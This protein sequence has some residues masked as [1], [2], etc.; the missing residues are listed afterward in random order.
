[1]TFVIISFFS[2]FNSAIGKDITNKKI[3]NLK[4]KINRIFLYS[5]YS[6]I[7]KGLNKTNNYVLIIL[8]ILAVISTLIYYVLINIFKLEELIIPFQIEF[9]SFFF[10]MAFGFNTKKKFSK[11]LKEIFRKLIKLYIVIAIL[12]NLI[13]LGSIKFL[14]TENT[15]HEILIINLKMLGIYFGVNVL[16]FFIYKLFPQLISVVLSFFYKYIAKQIAL[17]DKYDPIS[18]FFR[19]LSYLTAFTGLI[20]FVLAIFLNKP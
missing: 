3:I 16:L 10:V 5:C 18:G 20:Q 11:D 4:L 2:L 1:M 6:S 13:Y 7:R 17:K 14:F 12:L 15:I 8:S 9:I 19:Y